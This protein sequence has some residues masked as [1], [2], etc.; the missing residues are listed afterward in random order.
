MIHIRAVGIHKLPGSF[1]RVR[2]SRILS[3]F[4]CNHNMTDKD[5]ERESEEQDKY[6]P[7]VEVVYEHL[8]LLC[9]VSTIWHHEVF[10]QNT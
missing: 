3:V 8:S 1:A 6:M 5:L 4:D 9:Y 10:C 7:A 2:V